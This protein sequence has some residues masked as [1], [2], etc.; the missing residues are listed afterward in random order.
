MVDD[1]V[2][3][4]LAHRFT[5]SII[6]LHCIYGDFPL[7]L[8]NAARDSHPGMRSGE[9]VCRHLLPSLHD[10]AKS[11]IP[12]RHLTGWNLDVPF[13]KYWVNEGN[14]KEMQA[15]YK[16]DIDS[17]FNPM[18][19]KHSIALNSG[20]GVITPSQIAQQFQ[21][22][23]GEKDKGAVYTPDSAV[24]N[25]CKRAVLAH[26]RKRH[27]KI[28]KKNLKRWLT[29]SSKSG[30]RKVQL[31]RLLRSL[32]KIKICDPAVGTGAFLE[33]MIRLISRLG[34][35]H[36]LLEFGDGEG[37]YSFVEHLLEN[38]L[39]GTDIDCEALLYCEFRL[40]MAGVGIALDEGLSDVDISIPNLRE[41][42]SLTVDW[43]EIYPEVFVE[44]GG[45]EIVIMNP[46]YVST[47]NSAKL[48]WIDDVKARFGF[49]GDLYRYFI[50]LTIGGSKEVPVITQT[51]GIVCCI[52]SDSY[53][54]AKGSQDLRKL[55]LQHKLIS[56]V[57]CNVFPS[58]IDSAIFIC[59]NEPVPKN[60]QFHFL[61]AR[62]HKRELDN[63]ALE[64]GTPIPLTLF[65]NNYLSA[66][67]DP[68]KVNTAL[69]KDFFQGPKG[70][71]SQIENWGK[72]IHN[73]NSYNKNREE[74]EQHLLKLKPG[75]NTLIGLVCEGGQGIS[76]NCN[77]KFIACLEGTREAEGALE[78]RRRLQA[79]WSNNIE[80]VGPIENWSEKSDFE[81]QLDML[82]EHYNT[83]E[84]RK[85]VLEINSR[86]ILKIISKSDVY[87]IRPNLREERVEE[88]RKHG[89]SGT[90]KYIPFYKGD[91]DGN[92][93][94]AKSPLYIDWSQESVASFP[95]YDA[96]I[97]NLHLQLNKGVTWTRTCGHSP[98][99]ARLQERCIFAS[100]SPR[101]TPSSGII[102]EKAFLA[103]LNSSFL[104]YLVKRLMQNNIKY[105]VNTIKHAPLV[106]PTKAQDTELSNLVD[107][108]ITEK[109][110]LSNGRGSEEALSDIERE[111]NHAV[112]DLYGVVND[113]DSFDNLS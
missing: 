31:D 109:K 112:A 91:R 19:E 18:F 8:K 30:L 105:E 6:S 55:L 95:H 7:I 4:E 16:V 97:R 56:L 46:P 39:F 113:V 2:N 65:E 92:R 57:Q 9:I 27:P 34:A 111:I 93:W 79:L 78:E 74:I 47:Q 77:Q 1:G 53:Y 99:K 100:D 24:D 29:G 67:F 43:A 12:L 25:M 50:T 102:S 11:D 82:L 68:N 75:D 104:S 84:Q 103:I 76:T 48:D 96:S 69:Q 64:A 71:V 58:T 60:H 81:S 101:L 3:R 42:N 63:S 54:T 26:L 88:I 20:E 94:S 28:A 40:L 110:L 14:E 66:F 44:G 80:I 62:K 45:F 15:L 87:H 98:I 52:S 5:L 22:L 49:K 89:L 21:F 70:S 61:Q 35:G 36:D 51:G 59:A 38:V 86:K 107:D 83:P 37:Q 106:I 41:C 17:L 90:K 73:S 13:L 23:V 85:E 33:G 72:K 32:L 10:T 108:V